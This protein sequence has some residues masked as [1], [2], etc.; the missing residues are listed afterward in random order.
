[1][2]NGLSDC[3]EGAGS[4][5]RGS[6]CVGNAEDL[7]RQADG[8]LAF[9]PSG[10]S[11]REIVD[12]HPSQTKTQSRLHVHS[13]LNRAHGVLAMAHLLCAPSCRIRQPSLA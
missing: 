3:G 2:H 11:P 10:S 8:L 12:E 5:S 6:R 4:T 9:R 13:G 7:R 1:M